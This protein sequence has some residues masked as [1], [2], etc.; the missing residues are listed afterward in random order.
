MAFNGYTEI[1]GSVAKFP[2]VSFPPPYIISSNPAVVGP[3]ATT[4]I[5]IIG[6]IFSS[7]TQVVIGGCSVNSITAISVN[8]LSVNITAGVVQALFDITVTNTGG[9]ATLTNGI[10]IFAIPWIDLRLGGATFTSGNGAGNDIRFKAG[11]TMTR[12]ATG[13]YFSG[14]SPWSSWVKFESL[15]W[16]RGTNKTLSWIYSQPANNMMIGISST[17]T[18]E[19]STAQYSQFE[20]SVYYSNSTSLWG[21][22]GN[23]GT[24]GSAGNVSQTVSIGSGT[25]KSVYTN[26]GGL[27]GTVTTYLLPSAA[28]IDWDDI[29]NPVSTITIGGSL[30][31]SQPNIMPG[32]IPQNGGT[33]RFI[34]VYIA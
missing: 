6:G 22:Y 3:G 25:Y 32:I 18:N 10:Q 23:N 4:S 2:K 30:N 21:L 24:L 16:I 27:G 33:Q 11:M 14:S 7:T 31:P 8:E 13:M 17:A 34:A 12:D 9:S 26:D 29:S 1:S 5:T 28:Q 15:A 20:L 19:A